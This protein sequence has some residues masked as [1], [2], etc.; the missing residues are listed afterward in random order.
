MFYVAAF[1][2]LISSYASASVPPGTG[3]KFLLQAIVTNATYGGR[4]YAHSRQVT[5]DGLLQQLSSM[6]DTGLIRK[7]CIYRSMIKVPW[8]TQVIYHWYIVLQ[9]RDGWWMSI[10]VNRRGHVIIQIGSFYY[11]KHTLL[12]MPRYGVTLVICRAGRMTVIALFGQLKTFA[13]YYNIQFRNGVDIVFSFKLFWITTGTGWSMII[14]SSSIAIVDRREMM[15]P[16]VLQLTPD[17]LLQLLRYMID[18]G[19]I[20]RVYFIRCL[21]NVPWHNTMIYHWFVVLQTRNGWWMSIELDRGGHIIVQTGS[22]NDVRNRFMGKPRIRTALV[23]Y[24]LGVKTLGDLINWL[25]TI[26]L[27]Y[28]RQFRYLVDKY[29]AYRVFI[30]LTQ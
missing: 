27:Y 28:Y 15:G 2:L 30:Y 18:T 14:G 24:G 8:N 13:L 29:F 11:V 12:D 19:L 3:S 7:V 23:K 26:L 22:Y 25:K 6:M 16:L 20:R 10:D 5:P 1:L 4:D 17:E 21:V 9:T